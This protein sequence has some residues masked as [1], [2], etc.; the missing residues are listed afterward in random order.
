MTELLT[1]AFRDFRVQEEVAAHPESRP[2]AA[3][4]TIPFSVPKICQSFQRIIR[5]RRSKP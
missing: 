2:K 4:D 3:V 5:S 1:R